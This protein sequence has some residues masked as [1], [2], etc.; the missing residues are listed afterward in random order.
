MNRAGYKLTRL[1]KGASTIR[2]WQL[3]IESYAVKEGDVV[4]MGQELCVI[5]A[6]KMQNVIWSHEAGAVV[7]KLHGE[8]VHLSVQ[9]RF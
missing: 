5:E 6:M 3:C 2:L 9:M 1:I 4:E 8:V 7:S